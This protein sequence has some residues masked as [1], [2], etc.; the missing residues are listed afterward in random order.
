MSFRLAVIVAL[1]L[2]GAAGAASAATA[3]AGPAQSVRV[4]YADLDLSHDAGVSALYARLR[5]AA[6]QVCNASDAIDL[7]SQVAYR[8]CAA[9][10]LDEA[11]AS[12]NDAKLTAVHA[13]VRT[14]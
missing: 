4:A 1:G 8:D 10:A 14:G 7:R 6:S 3:A 11:V 9:R 2:T 13:R 12:V 5:S